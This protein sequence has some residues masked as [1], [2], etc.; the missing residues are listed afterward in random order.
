MAWKIEDYEGRKTVLCEDTS[1]D[2]ATLITA[3]VR[4]GKL[5]LRGRDEGSSMKSFLGVERYEYTYTFDEDNTIKLF[6]FL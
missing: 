3:E 1:P 4:K 2:F 6:Y 5:I